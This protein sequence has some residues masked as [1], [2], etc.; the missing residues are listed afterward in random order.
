MKEDVMSKISG[1]IWIVFQGLG[2]YR[3]F[4]GGILGSDCGVIYQTG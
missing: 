3:R 2:L 1:L 4:H